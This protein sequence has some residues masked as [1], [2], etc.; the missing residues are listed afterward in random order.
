MDA[1]K[2]VEEIALGATFA[3]EVGLGA[4]FARSLRTDRIALREITDTGG[5]EGIEFV[6]GATE[7]ASA[8]I[9]VI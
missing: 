4:L 7:P 1:L 9:V 3:V 8:V 2:V 6:S 5:K